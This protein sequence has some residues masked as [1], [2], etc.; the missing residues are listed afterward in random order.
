MTVSS[1]EELLDED[2]VDSIGRT[3]GTGR[4]GGPM[5]PQILPVPG[6]KSFSFKSSSIS[7]CPPIFSDLPTAL[8]F[9]SLT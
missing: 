4:T 3:V 7:L 6:A 1:D 8:A 2:G 9:C 5:L